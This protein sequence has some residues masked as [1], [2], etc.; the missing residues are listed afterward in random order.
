MRM[1]AVVLAEKPPIE[2]ETA[3]VS[4]TLLDELIHNIGSLASVYHKS[5]S[6]LGGNAMEISRVRETY[7]SSLTKRS[8]VGE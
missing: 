5:P 3:T 1:Q 4:E 6:L 8:V 7:V 2:A